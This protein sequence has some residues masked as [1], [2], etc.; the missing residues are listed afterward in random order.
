MK[1]NYWINLEQTCKDYISITSAQKYVLSIW[2][3]WV[4]NQ[5]CFEMKIVGPS[6]LIA[7]RCQKPAIPALASHDP[8]TLHEPSVL[9]AEKSCWNWMINT[10]FLR[11]CSYNYYYPTRHEF[12][13]VELLGIN[14]LQKTG[15]RLLST[16]ECTFECNRVQSWAQ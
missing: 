1:P 16:R 8:K 6:G 10:L 4:D 11:L 7:Y 13:T 15:F 2:I 9:E 12:R 14:E 3:L 5:C